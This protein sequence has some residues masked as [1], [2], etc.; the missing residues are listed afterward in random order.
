MT[1][2]H[3]PHVR[4]AALAAVRAGAPYARVAAQHGVSDRAIRNWCDEAGMERRRPGKPSEPMDDIPFTGR[5]VRD[6]LIWRQEG[7]A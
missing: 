2:A 4:E 6:G 5:W 1:A 3:P 7:A